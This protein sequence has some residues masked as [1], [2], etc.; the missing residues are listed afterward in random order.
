M[1]DFDNDYLKDILTDRLIILVNKII[2]QTI[3]PFGVYQDYSVIVGLGQLYYIK[4]QLAPSFD[5][6][7]TLSVKNIFTDQT[8]L[9]NY[10]D[11]LNYDSL[12]LTIKNLQ[13]QFK[14]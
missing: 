3:I 11:F 10:V 13:Q 14:A 7:V 1:E 5:F 4:L 12:L 8:Y 9:T 6:V 2:S